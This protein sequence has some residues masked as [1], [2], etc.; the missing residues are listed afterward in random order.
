MP[1]FLAAARDFSQPLFV[2][3]SPRLVRLGVEVLF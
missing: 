1:L 2:Y 3:D